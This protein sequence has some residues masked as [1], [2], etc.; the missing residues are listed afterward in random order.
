MRTISQ[1]FVKD[2]CNQKKFSLDYRRATFSSLICNNLMK[3]EDVLLELK[4]LL[5][6]PLI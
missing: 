3:R 1:N 5:R 6:I 4:N 2:T